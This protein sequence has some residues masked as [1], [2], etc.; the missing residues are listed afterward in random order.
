MRMIYIYIY[1]YIKPISNKTIEL[2]FV[3]SL[4]MTIFTLYIILFWK[5]SGLQGARVK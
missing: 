3:L 5:G 2:L 1:S 4:N